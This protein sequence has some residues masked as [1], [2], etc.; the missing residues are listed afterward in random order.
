[1]YFYTDCLAFRQ[2]SH[3][4]ISIDFLQIISPRNEI[5]VFS[6]GILTKQSKFKK[7]YKNVKFFFILHTCIIWRHSGIYV[8]CKTEIPPMVASQT[9]A[10]IYDPLPY[11]EVAVNADPNRGFRWW[12]EWNWIEKWN[13][14]L[15]IPDWF[16][17]LHRKWNC[18]WHMHS[19]VKITQK[20]RLL[21]VE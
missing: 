4:S 7:I 12:Q 3:I 16:L 13:S 10:K 14:D 17:K 20:S 15:W 8:F 6:N 5:H 11:F 1:M 19:A 9:T 21:V 2:H 18:E